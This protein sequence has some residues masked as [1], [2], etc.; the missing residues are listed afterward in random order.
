MLYRTYEDIIKINAKEKAENHTGVVNT[1]R[2]THHHQGRDIAIHRLLMIAATPVIMKEIQGILTLYA[3]ID[4]CR[5][6]LGI[7]RL[8]PLYQ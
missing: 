7:S 6:G 5:I 3:R 4:I 2:K 1:T 8:D